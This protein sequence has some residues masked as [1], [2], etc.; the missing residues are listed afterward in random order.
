[1]RIQRIRICENTVKCTSFTDTQNYLL[2]LTL[3]DSGFPRGTYVRI[4]WG[5]LK[6]WEAFKNIADRVSDSQSDA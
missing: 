1:M 2:K 6:T 5:L 4:T 3:K